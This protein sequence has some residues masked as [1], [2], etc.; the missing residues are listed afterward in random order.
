MNNEYFNSVEKTD[1]L[2][3]EVFGDDL[4][5]LK[6]IGVVEENLFLRTPAVEEEKSSGSEKTATS[7]EKINQMNN[8]VAV[9]SKSAI[10]E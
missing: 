2:I 1:N 7:T 9:E 5:P 10:K 4:A 6:K 3:K 8:D